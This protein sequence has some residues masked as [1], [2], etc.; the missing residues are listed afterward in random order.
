MA[1]V[2]PPGGIDAASTLT[3]L[4]RRCG[5]K[6][7]RDGRL[8]R[9]RAITRPRHRQQQG[10]SR[11]PV[12]GCPIAP[13]IAKRSQLSRRATLNDNLS[14]DRGQPSQCPQRHRFGHRERKVDEIFGFSN[15]T[16]RLRRQIIDRAGRLGALIGDYP[17]VGHLTDEEGVRI[18]RLV[19]YHLS[20]SIR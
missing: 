19:R 16:D 9:S 6:R 7:A 17:L 3:S 11:A 18:L 15:A 1:A 10:R 12:R 4:P 14:P 13:E 5:R 20:C 2:K 8:R